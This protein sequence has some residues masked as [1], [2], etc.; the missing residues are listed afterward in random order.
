[1]NDQDM[2]RYSIGIEFEGS[3]PREMVF[4]VSVDGKPRAY[5]TYDQVKAA[6]AMFE[7]MVSTGGRVR[8]AGG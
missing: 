7:K 8:Q 6:M 4:S 1:M 3:P 5:P 2:K